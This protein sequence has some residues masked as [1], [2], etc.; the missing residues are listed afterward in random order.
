MSRRVLVVGAGI[1][2]LTAAACLSRSGF[3][4]AV[5]ERSERLRAD[6]AGITLW[7]NALDIFE[8]FG[9]GEP[10]V[11]AGYPVANLRVLDPDGREASTY[12]G[13]GDIEE[14]FGWPVIVIYRPT[15]SEILAETLPA[16][17]LRFSARLVDL[18]ETDNT[19]TAYFGDGS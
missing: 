17:A 2:G 9:V 12:R 15:L 7:P 16:G 1:V 18:K 11:A 14:R 3:D 8:T 4:V 6:G 10:I 19:V 5:C 13:F